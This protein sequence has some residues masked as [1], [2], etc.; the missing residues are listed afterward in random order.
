MDKVHKISNSNCYTPSSEPFKLCLFC[1]MFFC[2]LFWKPS[3]I[4][5]WNQ[6]RHW[7]IA[8]AE[9]RLT[10]RWC[11]ISSIITRWWSRIMSLACSL[12]SS[13]LDVD[14]HPSRDS[15]LIIAH[16]FWEWLSIC[17]HQEMFRFCVENP[18]S[19]SAPGISSVH[20]FRLLPT[21]LLCNIRKVGWAR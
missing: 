19:I 8:W 6:S 20:K 11:A 5:L 4:N 3:Y 12:L 14:L 18:R 16:R 17:F 2:E 9:P 1:I 7:M 13:A 10:L 21:T 15:P